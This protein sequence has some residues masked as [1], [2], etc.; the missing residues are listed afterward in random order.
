MHPFWAVSR[1]SAKELEKK[2][3]EGLARQVFNMELV[4]KE[5]N[6]VTVGALKAES[7]SMTTTVTVPLMV[8][9]KDVKKG[10]ELI[11][12]T[13]AVAAKHKRK[14]ASWKDDAVSSTTPKKEKPGAKGKEAGASKAGSIEI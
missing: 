4:D 6:V 5:F 8:N 12:E 2:N 13:A 1:L 14:A 9:S 3:A 7:V 11:L 10:D